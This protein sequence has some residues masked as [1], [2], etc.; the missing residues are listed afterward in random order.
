MKTVGISLLLLALILLI[1]CSHN[2]SRAAMQ[3]S[4]QL[5]FDGEAEILQSWQGDY[6]MTHLDQLPDDQR[7]NPVGFIGDAKTFKNVWN[8]FKPSEPA[9]KID[10]KYH[11]VL[12]AR[13]TQFYNRISI[14]KVNVDNGVAEILAMETRSARPI[15][16]K[17]AL[18]LVVI[19]REGITGIQFG[20]RVIPAPKHSN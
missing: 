15:E 2:D 19:A 7:D 17:A 1:G 11:L 14:G 8:A 3:Q 6:P 10:F 12:F 9:P 13:N 20:D 4:K 16:N 5:P 18:S